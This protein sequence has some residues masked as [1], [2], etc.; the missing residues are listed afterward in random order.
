GSGHSRA[1]CGAARC[2]HRPVQAPGADRRRGHG[3]GVAGPAARAG[4]TAGGRQAHQGRDGLETGH[5]PLRGGAAGAGADG[6]RPHRPR[7]GRRADRRRPAVLRHGPGQGGGDH[8]LPRRAP[9]HA[10]A[11]ARVVPPRL[12]G[13]AARA[14]EGRHPPRPQAVQ[15]PGGPVRRPA[16]AQGHRLRR[17]QVAGQPLTEQTLVTGFG[18]VVGT[19]EYMSPEQAELNQLDI[20]TRSDIYSLGV[21]LYELLTGTT[22]LDR[23]RLQEVAM[24][25]ILRLIREEEPPRPST[26]LSTTAAMPA[27]AANRGLAPNR[28]NGLVRGGLGWVGIE[29]L[30]KAADRRE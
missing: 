7:A 19:L 10:Q 15:R 23:R 1:P 11:E 17:G 8:P 4:K 30:G 3:S 16:G 24:L 2:P 27:I 21:L 6:P 12:P 13:G 29:A 25:E 14:P 20:D 5:R 22:P 26:R 9:P 18:A 28:L